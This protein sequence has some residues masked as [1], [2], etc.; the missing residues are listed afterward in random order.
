MAPPSHLCWSMWHH[1]HT[2]VGQC[3]TITTSVGQVG[4][5]TTSVLANMA[6][7]PP[8]FCWPMWHHHHICVGQCGTI[9]TPVLAYVAPPP[10]LCRP[11]WHHHHTC[12]G[13]CRTTTTPVTS[14]NRRSLNRSQAG[15]ETDAFG[16]CAMYFPALSPLSLIH[17]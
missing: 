5:I 2:R 6:P 4:T 11:I 17:I 7:P 16:M 13:Q 12:A 3:G 10:H 9:T 15:Q 1:H 14:L 8:H